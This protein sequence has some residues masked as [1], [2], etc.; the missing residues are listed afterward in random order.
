MIRFYIGA[1]RGRKAFA[2]WAGA[3]C[4]LFLTRR[5][6]EIGRRPAYITDNPFKPGILDKTLRLCHNRR[7]AAAGNPAALVEGNGAKVT[8]TKTAPVL[9]DRKLHFRNG[10]DTALF[11]IRRMVH[12]LKRHGKYCI[13]FRC[14]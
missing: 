5:M 9:H 7:D 8:G 10:R 13:Q 2:V 1:G 6:P 11:F 3:F 12:P 14:I 4:Q